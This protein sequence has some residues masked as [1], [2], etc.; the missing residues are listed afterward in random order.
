M[1]GPER[2]LTMSDE[3]SRNWKCV[4]KGLENAFLGTPSVKA[5]NKDEWHKFLKTV[6]EDKQGVARMHKLIQ[7]GGDSKKSQFHDSATSRL[8]K[9][10]SDKE[11][12]TKKPEDKTAER[13]EKEKSFTKVKASTNPAREKRQTL[14]WEELEPSGET[15]LFDTSTNKEAERLNDN[16]AVEEA[17]GYAFVS[18]DSLPKKFGD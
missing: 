9:F 8:G 10:F 5:M 18:A 1:W 3:Y 6:K 7:A 4:D 16:D 11:K 17:E 12:A 15:K 14:P 2:H 13:N